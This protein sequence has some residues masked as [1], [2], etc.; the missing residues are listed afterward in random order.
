METTILEV[1]LKQGI[2]AAVAVFLLLY[3]V[4]SNEKRDIRQEEREQN[5]QSVINK[6]TEAFSVLHT[7][8]DDIAQIRECFI[9]SDKKQQDS[10]EAPEEKQ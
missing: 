8:R 2:W 9:S 4:K 5:Y 3:I 6:L 10:R 7:I 1:A